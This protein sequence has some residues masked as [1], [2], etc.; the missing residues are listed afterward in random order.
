M[1]GEENFDGVVTDVTAEETGKKP[2][3]KPVEK[4][5][6]DVAAQ[7]SIE[8]PKPEAEGAPKVEEEQKK[9]VVEPPKP[10]IDKD[11]VQRRIDR[12][13][14]RLQEERSRRLAAERTTTIP[15]AKEDDEDADEKPRGLTQAEAEAIWNRKEL[16]RKFKESETKVLMRHSDCLNDDGSFNMNSEFTKEYLTIGRENPNLAFMHNGPELAEAMVEK[17]LNLGYKKGAKD[18]VADTAKAQ[19]AHTGASTVAVNAAKVVKLPDFKKRI[20]ARMGMTEADYMA[21]EEKISKGDKKVNM[22]GRSAPK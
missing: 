16:E 5:K 11:E 6:E 4:P 7:P 13:Y 8:A 21:Y 2:Q 20:A 10:S 12:M 17:R 3:E 14:A 1:A 19:N 9:V 15:K 18:A 22:Y